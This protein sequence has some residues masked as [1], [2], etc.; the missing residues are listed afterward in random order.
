MEIEFGRITILVDDYDEAFAFYEKALQCKKFF[1]IEGNG[2]RFLHV[3]FNAKDKSGIW[4]IR[5]E[6]DE[7]KN[8]VGNQTGG[9]P[10]FVIY[11]DS[12]YELYD[13]LKRNEISIS[14][15]ISETEDSRDFHFLDLYG[16]EIVVVE[17]KVKVDPVS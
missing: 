4:F 5:A 15:E 7:Q 11:T 8:L 3:G 2:K 12:M 16:N 14:K 13:N 1:D 10:L 6:S 17:I 9:M